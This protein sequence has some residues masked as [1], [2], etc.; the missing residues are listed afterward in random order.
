MPGGAVGHG[1]QPGRS[2]AAHPCCRDKAC[3]WQG[4]VWGGV[5][6]PASDAL[7]V[8]AGRAGHG[9]WGAESP[10]FAQVLTG[11]AFGAPAAQDTEGV[12]EHGLGCLVPPQ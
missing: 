2:Y 1:Y 8:L 7:S 5:Q 10:R 3:A 9:S 12:L 6:T 11:V 4:L